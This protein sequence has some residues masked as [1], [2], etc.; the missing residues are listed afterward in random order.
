MKAG[1]QASRLCARPA[2]GESG[3]AGIPAVRTACRILDAVTG[4]SEEV[5]MNEAAGR[6]CGEYIYVYPPG[7][8]ILAPGEYIESEHLRIIRQA[9]TDGAAVRHTHA[10]GRRTIVCLEE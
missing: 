1:L 7:I 5:P 4:C 2:A 9:E 6:I 10:G 3:P 8:P